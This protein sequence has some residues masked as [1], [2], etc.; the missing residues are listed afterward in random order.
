[1]RQVVRVVDESKENGSELADLCWA[2][3]DLSSECRQVLTLR[4]VYGWGHDRIAAHLGIGRHEVESDLRDCVR[5]I[6]RYYEQS[7]RMH[8]EPYG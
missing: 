6:A 2:V 1:M 8:R 5:S 7:Q 3:A 4:K